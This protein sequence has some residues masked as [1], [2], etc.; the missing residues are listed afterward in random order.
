[1]FGIVY[2]VQY[3]LI[4]WLSESLHLSGAEEKL[5]LSGFY[6]SSSAERE[7]RHLVSRGMEAKP[8]KP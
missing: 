4:G 7:M 2:F 1:M 6:K 5:M 8:A 3:P